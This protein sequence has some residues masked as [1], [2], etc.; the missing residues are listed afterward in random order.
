MELVPNCRANLGIGMPEG[1]AAV[2]A[3]EGIGDSLTLTVEA[4]GFG[5]VP[6]AGLSFGA[7]VNV[8]AMIDHAAM[9]DFYD[10]GVT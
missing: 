2:A 3:E 7:T 10:G 9:F 8:E 1:L 5:G 6:A 4:G